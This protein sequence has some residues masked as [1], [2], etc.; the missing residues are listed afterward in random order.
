MPQGGLAAAV[1]GVVGIEV[2]VEQ[3]PF[4][5][6]GGAA[7]HLAAE[8]GDAR[9]NPLPRNAEQQPLPGAVIL[10]AHV[11]QTAD[12]HLSRRDVFGG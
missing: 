2:V 12:V 3:R 9:A 6:M 1:F 7:R 5:K 4:T 8:G 11:R 10:G